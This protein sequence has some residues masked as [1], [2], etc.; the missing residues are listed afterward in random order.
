[1]LMAHS[2]I[3][4][5]LRMLENKIR[6]DAAAC[7]KKYFVAASIA[8]GWGVLVISGIMARVLISRPI[9]ARIQWKLDSVK[10]VPRARL[11]MIIDRAYGLI[12]K[13]GVLTNMFGVWAQKLA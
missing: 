2:P 4:Y 8:R 9:Q 3:K 13:G 10:M 1:M 5:A 12:S 11:E 7:V 6:A